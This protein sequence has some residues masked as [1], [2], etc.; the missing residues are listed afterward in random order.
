MRNLIYVLAAAALFTAA[1]GAPVKQGSPYGYDSYYS[2][3]SPALKEPVKPLPGE[4][5]AAPAQPEAA[6]PAAVQ[7][8]A[9][10]P[11]ASAKP[12]EAAPAPEAPAAAPSV[13]SAT[14][15]QQAAAPVAI[16]PADEGVIASTVTAKGSLDVIS[17]KLDKGL[18][19]LKLKVGNSTGKFWKRNWGY[20]FRFRFYDTADALVSLTKKVALVDR[21]IDTGKNETVTFALKMPQ[22]LS[23]NGGTITIALVTEGAEI[24]AVSAPLKAEAKPAAPA[25]EPE[26]LPEAPAPAPTK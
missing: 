26:P 10:A 25:A 3:S 21:D 7:P 17:V 24:A 16:E 2:Q 8:A 4:Q 6:A 19:Q 5:A 20:G 12:A 23:L 9:T 11:E 22:Q 15:T 14:S 1:C 13:S 18:V